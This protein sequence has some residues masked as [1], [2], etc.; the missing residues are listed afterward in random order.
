MSYRHTGQPREGQ[1]GETPFSLTYREEAIIPAKINLCCARVSGFNPA[2]NSESMLKQLNLLEE[3]RESAI[4][5]LAE[6]QQKL[7]QRYNR[8]VRSREFGVGG[9]V[10]QKVVGNTQDINTGKLAP[11]CEETYRVNAIT[12]IGA[13]YLEDMDERPLPW[14]WNVHNLKKLYH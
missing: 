1:R 7:S 5:Q 4:M 12:G 2:E 3:R 14:P 10:L 11:T 13:Y 8:N 9:L 6:Y